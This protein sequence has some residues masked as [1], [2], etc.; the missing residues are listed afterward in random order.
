MSTVISDL[1]H[2]NH[3]APVF[4]KTGC[5]SIIV[6]FITFFL[7]LF[8]VLQTHNYWVNTNIYFEQ[9]KVSHT[10]EIVV[11]LYTDDGVYTF[12]S[13]KSLNGLVSGGS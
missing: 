3:S 12:G 10:N 5:V 9:P 7:P 13:T 1:L 4:S 11:F 8:L 6:V 2:K